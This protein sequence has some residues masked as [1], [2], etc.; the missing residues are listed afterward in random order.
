MDASKCIGCTACM[1]IGCPAISMK[2]KKA[3]VDPTQC[4]GC[5]VCAQLCK[6]SA[7]KEV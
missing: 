1:K 4:V 6:L 7:L 3:V 5:G 2:D